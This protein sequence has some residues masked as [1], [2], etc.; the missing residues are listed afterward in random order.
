MSQA[1]SA[2]NSKVAVLVSFSGAGGVE[3]MMAHLCEGMA[4]AGA[5][6]D[7]LVI[8]DRSRY[9]AAVP[10]T[11]RVRKLRAS[12][13]ATALPE[14]T[15]YLRRE[16]PDA[17][18]AAKDRANRVAILAGRLAGGGTHVAVR[19]GTHVSASLAGDAPIKQWIWQRAIRLFY[20]RAD[21][22]ICNS[23]GIAADLATIARLPEDRITVIKNP[24]I[25]PRLDVLAHAPPPHPWL[26]DPAVPVILGAGR[27]TR[28]KDFPTLIRAFSLLRRRRVCRLLIIGEGADRGRLLDLAA[29]LD[30]AD[31]VDLPGFVDNPYAYMRKASLFVLSSIWEGAPNVLVEAMACGTPVAATN[32]PSGPMEI[33]D[34]G[35]HGPLTPPGDPVALA[36]AMDRVLTAPPPPEAMRAAVAEYTVE[37]SARSYLRALLG[38]RHAAFHRP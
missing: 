11:V 12:H 21:A 3:R 34:G 6:V 5:R 27:L 18:L 24:V 2:E 15:R 16:R 4:E 30:V 20:G 38:K 1:L 26:I 36:G 8:R 9:L 32:C 13:A 35:R 7:L 22:V 31:A 33:L 37:N 29:H 14:L 19:M 23:R 10:D 17:L 25:T 28:Q